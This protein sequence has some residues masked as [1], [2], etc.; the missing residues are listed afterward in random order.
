[1]AGAARAT[2]P[3]LG[4]TRAA[5]SARSARTAGSTRATGRVRRMNASGSRPTMISRRT[6]RW[7]AR[8]GVGR[9]GTHPQ[10]GGP[11]GA[12]DGDPPK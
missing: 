11:K 6:G 1:M 12:R 7:S 5:G 4:S 10:R 8:S 9:T 2:G 3:T